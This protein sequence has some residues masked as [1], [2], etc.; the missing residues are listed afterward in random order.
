LPHIWQSKIEEI[1]KEYGMNFEPWL[2]SANSYRE[3]SENLKKRGFTNLSP[4]MTPIMDFSEYKNFPKA[5]TSSC[6]V[7]KTMIKKIKT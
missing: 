1:I 6:K 4:G 5:N 7:M 3:L 2:E